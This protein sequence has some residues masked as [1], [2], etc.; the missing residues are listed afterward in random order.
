MDLRRGKENGL[1]T[2]GLRFLCTASAFLILP[3]YVVARILFKIAIVRDN[4][5]SFFKHP[6]VRYL[7]DG[8]GAKIDAIKNNRPEEQAESGKGFACFRQEI[9][10]GKAWFLSQNKERITVTSYDGLKLAAYYLPAE[11]D[12]DRVM[13]LM[14]G[15]R[16]D[17]FGDFS[18]LA[19][20]YHSMGYHLLVP[21]QRSHGKSEGTYICYGVKER[22][23]LKQ[24][25]EYAVSRFEGKCSV[26]LSGISMGGA[27]VLMAAD[28]EL[29][30]Q[31]KGII[32]DCAFTSPWDTFSHV[33]KMD[34]HLPRFPFL[35]AAD[36]VCRNRA[37]FRFK[38]CSTISCMKRNKI[39]V[40]FIHGGSDTFVPTEMTYKNYEACAAPKEIL[41]V[42]QAAH[43]TSNLVEPEVYRS[44]VINFMEK[45]TDG[46]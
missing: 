6:A 14:H 36:Y 24:W 33:M 21:H 35:Y 27:T 40:L 44:T 8:I 19:E 37:G 45:W 11:G 9:E 15:Y 32:A 10:A 23:D 13:I 34:Y 20:F 5:I 12:S 22:Y 2:K 26:F 31:V 28:L 39:P 17:G 18:G 7:M 4:E 3:V 16:N 46:N 1:W 42:D 25:A 29:P 30:T 38:E 43:G 41:I